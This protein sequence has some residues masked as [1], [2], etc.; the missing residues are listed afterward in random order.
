LLNDF[1]SCFTSLSIADIVIN[2]TGFLDSFVATLGTLVEDLVSYYIPQITAARIYNL[3][4]DIIQIIKDP[5]YSDHGFWD[6]APR[7]AGQAAT[8]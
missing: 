2:G 5:N 1:I 3:V 8:L 7:A 6:N 4:R